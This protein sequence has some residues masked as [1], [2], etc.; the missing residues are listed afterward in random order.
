MKDLPKLLC[1]LLIPACASA[2]GLDIAR[3]FAAPDL[4]GE[5][6]RSARFSPDNRL[7][8][9]L[10][11]K[12]LDK[13]RYDLWAYDIASRR[14][15]LLVDADRFGAAIPLS[16]EEAER[17][18][19][20]RTSSLSGIVDYSFAA[21]GKRLLVPQNGDLYLYDLTRPAA[22]AVRRLT[23]TTAYETDARFSP[24]GRFVSFIREQ[25]L[26][27]IDLATGREQALTSA[28]GGLISFGMAEFIAQEEMDRDTG[29]WW[30]PDERTIAVA[31]VDDS[32]V[33]EAERFEIMADGVKVVRQRYPYAGTANAAVTLQLIAID[34]GEQ[35]PVALSSF[36]YLARVD[37]LPDSSG[38]IVQTQSR[39]Q[40]Q[41]ELQH[42]SA[43]DGRAR[44][45]FIEHSDS[46]VPLTRSLTLLP[47]RRQFILASS[48]SGFQHLY[49]FDY[50][51]Q[52]LRPL[53]GGEWTVIDGGR[54]GTIRGID[55]AE[56]TIYF[57]ANKDTVVERH[58]Y[59]LDIA[60][61]DAEPRRVTAEGGWH[62]VTMSPNAGLFL[63]TFST[64][65]QPPRVAL[66]RA[67]GREL[68]VLIENKLD[69]AH[70]YAPYAD[71][72]RPTE[73]GTLTAEDGQTLHYQML[74][75]ADM[76]PGKRYPAII[77]VYGG[78]GYQ[79]VRRAW[80][81]YPRSNE[82]YFR[83]IL[84]QHGYVVFTLDNRGSGFRG[85]RF[86]AAGF[87]HLG[88][89]EVRDQVRGAEFLS[90]LDFVD[91]KRIGVFGWSYGGYMTLMCLMQAPDTFAA[92]AAGAPVTDWRLYDTHYTERYM[93]TPA[94]NPDG[95]RDSNVLSFANNLRGR[96]LLMH[97]MADDNVLFTHSTTLMSELQRLDK[98]FLVMPYPGSK[99]GLLR[100]ADTGPHAYHSIVD[101]FDRNL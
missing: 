55:Q 64:P 42:V 91:P 19:R 86:E 52:L 46:W 79:R 71:A 85:T 75:P 87:H 92:G 69:A 45:L 27:I 65:D 73:F 17:R 60:T 3:M 62:D 47:G 53:T 96:L 9:Y 21:D 66:R 2:T 20:Q 34:G 41:L 61:P 80:G 48:R 57:T 7:V 49:L 81:G 51:G 36:E 59:A 4:A 94:G 43:S 8:T 29:Y 38:L 6:L 23:N 30:S 98:A 97:G 67:D 84:A 83:Q 99:H 82:G 44:T 13:D 89:V 25:N 39:D 12:A 33:Q 56:R 37:W 93:G 68:A 16:A 77:D 1:L 76:Q 40:R 78:P 24:H 18:E 50:S 22:S 72:H 54:D 5:S 63:D 31:R 100:H 11:G 32:P 14:H 101:F 10:K 28:G 74:T 88:S 90:S 35:R 58:L 95:Y 15:R 70:P 26:Y